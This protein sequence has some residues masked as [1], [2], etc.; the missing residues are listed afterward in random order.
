MP[1]QTIN[2][3]KTREKSLSKGSTSKKNQ[4]EILE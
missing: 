2:M 4:I 1:Q 3:L